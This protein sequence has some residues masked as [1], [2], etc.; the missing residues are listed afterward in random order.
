MG[1]EISRV[2]RAEH[3]PALGRCDSC[4]RRRAAVAATADVVLDVA[5]GGMD[6]VELTR[7]VS[8]K[9]TSLTDDNAASVSEH[10]SAALSQQAAGGYIPIRSNHQR[11]CQTPARCATYPFSA[12]IQTKLDLQKPKFVVH[13]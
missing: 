7:L 9:R 6:P 11:L 1:D 13:C 3:W 5:H 12:R 2:E 4:R 8:Q 10:K